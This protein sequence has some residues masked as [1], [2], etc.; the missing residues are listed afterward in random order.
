MNTDRE[1]LINADENKMNT[2]KNSVHPNF[3]RR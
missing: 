1:N 2:D 3:H